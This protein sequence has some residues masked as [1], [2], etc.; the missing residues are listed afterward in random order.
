MVRADTNHLHE[1]HHAG[2]L[3]HEAIDSIDGIC[4][5]YR[6]M[7]PLHMHR[8]LIQAQKLKVLR[9]RTCSVSVCR[10]SA[11]PRAMPAKGIMHS[12]DQLIS[13]F[14]GPLKAERTRIRGLVCCHQ[15]HSLPAVLAKTAQVDALSTLSSSSCN[16]R[17]AHMSGKHMLQYHVTR[18]R[19]KMMC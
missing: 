8:S 7:R 6:K 19:Q 2:L 13:N 15:C 9:L 1:Q 11:S 16:L 4:F 3:Y 14:L 17:Q 5:C 10:V 12:I 18:N